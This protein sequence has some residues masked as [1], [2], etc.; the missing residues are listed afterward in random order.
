MRSVHPVH[1]SD[2]RLAPTIVPVD[3]SAVTPVSRLATL[4]RILLIGGVVMRRLTP[5]VVVG[6]FRRDGSRR[7][8]LLGQALSDAL[9]DL[10]VTFVKFGQLLASSPSLAG[11][12]VSKAM[13]GL[14][15]EGTAVSFNDVRR[16]I[17]KDLERPIESVFSRFEKLPF[18][19]A[20]LAVVHKATLRDG[21]EVAVK[22]L[23]PECARIVATDLSIL[24]PFARRISR[25]LPVGYLPSIPE[26]VEGLA[27]QLSEELDLRNEA[28]SMAWFTEMIELLG[29]RGVLVPRTMPHACG[30]RVLTMEYIEGSK[31]DDLE[32]IFNAGVDA[33]RAVEALIEAWFALTLCTGVFHGDIHAGNLLI[34]ASGDVGL[35]DWG[36]VGRL[37]DKSRDF[38]R[39]SLEGA[40]GDEGAWADVRDHVL[41][42]LPPDVL[43]SAELHPDEFVEMIRSQ[44]LAI[45]T[46]PFSEVDLTM[47]AP[48]TRIPAVPDSPTPTTRLERLRLFRDER[49]RA[50]RGEGIS[51]LAEPMGPPRGEILLMKQLLYFERYGKMFLR[52]RPLV[53]DPAVYQ[54][55]LRLPKV[56]GDEGERDLDAALGTG[57]S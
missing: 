44:T 20:S 47:L 52:D 14:L 27:E 24:R 6:F 41:T 34:T 29:A 36:I 15:D 32:E 53:Y 28:R 3:L 43:R 54:A 51:A 38:F 12:T 50:R 48:T 30:A 8:W 40:L 17:E 31:V 55:L 45:M 16:I 2:S 46:A 37:P 23:R 25:A 33:P 11:E 7:R 13:R 5:V 21:T 1:G 4:K 22:V 9:S 10:G 19:A 35:L 42:T 39:R 26:I 18:A 56:D 57:G 49:R